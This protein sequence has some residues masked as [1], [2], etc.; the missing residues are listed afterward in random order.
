MTISNNVHQCTPPHPTVLASMELL[1]YALSVCVQLAR[2][3]LETLRERVAVAGLAP[4]AAADTE[5]ADYAEHM[6]AIYREHAPE[7]QSSVPAL[8]EKYSGREAELL[9]T[10]RAKYGIKSG[11]VEKARLIRV[12]SQFHGAQ[13]VQEFEA[14][15]VAAAKVRALASAIVV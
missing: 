12:I 11:Q 5:P 15:L 14:D 1:T 13:L 9:E 2:L 6:A 7:K 3:S 8:L 4:A 10:I